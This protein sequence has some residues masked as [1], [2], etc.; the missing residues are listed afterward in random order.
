MTELWKQFPFTESTFFPRNSTRGEL[1]TKSLH[2]SFHVQGPF[3]QVW[4]WKGQVEQVTCWPATGQKGL[5]SV[6]CYVLKGENTVT[7]AHIPAIFNLSQA[8]GHER[9]LGSSS[10][11]S[12]KAKR[13]PPFHQSARLGGERPSCGG[14]YSM[15]KTCGKFPCSPSKPD[16]VC[17]LLAPKQHAVKTAHG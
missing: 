1:S 12:R 9:G 17:W 16:G 6:M 7:P 3:P 15:T 14:G 10:Q 13:P 8:A 11:L 5:A 4:N 2:T